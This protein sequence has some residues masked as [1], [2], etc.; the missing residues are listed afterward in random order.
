[1][2]ASKSKHDSPA[3]I[4]GNVY[5]IYVAV[6][7]CYRMKRG[8]TLFIE[9]Y[10]D[11]T[12]DEKSQFEVK[13]Y[14]SPLTDGHINL[15][16]TIKNWT[17]DDFEHTRFSSLILFTT[18]KIGKKAKILKFNKSSPEK[19]IAILKSIYNEN[20]TRHKKAEEADVLK[21]QKYIFSDKRK[22]AL[23]EIIKKITI[24]AGQPAI[25]DLYTNICDEYLKG[26]PEE[27]HRE[28][29][30]SIVGFILRPGKEGGWDISY[31]DFNSRIQAL[32][33]LCMNE[34]LSFPTI[35][36]QEGLLTAKKHAPLYVQKINE[37]E[38]QDVISQAMKDHTSAMKIITEE[39]SIYS[40]TFNNLKT[41]SEDLERKFLD[42]HRKSKRNCGNNIILSSQ[43]FYDSMT[44]CESHEFRGYATR[45]QDAFRN[46]VLHDLLD[47]K[48]K[49][50]NW[51]LI[52]K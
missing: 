40:V 29:I 46:G 5:Q 32:L 51:I 6:Q 18:Q 35:T 22:H 34:K 33:R 36:P 41:Y 31:E 9:K 45:P 2:S 27:L 7:Q 1:M 14:S 39:L 21:F 20:E 26:I 38:Y 28:F 12:I 30:D 13:H 47:S 24:L 42:T 23:I 17:D 50:L 8:E 37:I 11:V 4:K 15:W 10:G 3:S 25:N 19:R 52:K 49:K 43:D 16:K 44:I 48:E